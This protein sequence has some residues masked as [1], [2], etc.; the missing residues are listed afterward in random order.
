MQEVK[1]DL[2]FQSAALA[3]FQGVAEAYLVGLFEEYPKK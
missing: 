3:A 1:A 2:R